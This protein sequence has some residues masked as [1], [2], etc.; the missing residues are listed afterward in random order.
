V[1]SP[2]RFPLKLGRLERIKNE[3]TYSITKFGR[4]HVRI[5]VINGGIQTAFPINSPEARTLANN[6]WPKAVDADKRFLDW[7]FP[8]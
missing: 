8:V 3:F 2:S 6:G 4:L 7:L 5:A 1:D